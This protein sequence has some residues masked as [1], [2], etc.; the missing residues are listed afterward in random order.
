M[1]WYRKQGYQG[2]PVLE[3]YFRKKKTQGVLTFLFKYNKRW[4]VL[5]FNKCTLSYAPNKNKK[6]SN[7]FAFKDILDVASNQSVEQIR[8]AVTDKQLKDL[9]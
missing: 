2:Q 6:F 1:M 8:M 3:A 5:D 7:I 9:K 4:F